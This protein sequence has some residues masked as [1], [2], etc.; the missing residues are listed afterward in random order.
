MNLQ[1]K[2]ILSTKAT[3]K[4]ITPANEGENTRIAFIDALK[5]ATMTFPSFTFINKLTHVSRSCSSK[6]YIRIRT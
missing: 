3:K 4:S 2:M 6:E 5:L 1:K